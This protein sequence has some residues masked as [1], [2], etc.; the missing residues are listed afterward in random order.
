MTDDVIGTLV[1]DPPAWEPDDKNTA[2]MLEIAQ[3]PNWFA[4]PSI[5]WKCIPLQHNTGNDT[6]L[7]HT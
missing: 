1:L 5:A 2:N 6:A 7:Y 3:Q 4:W